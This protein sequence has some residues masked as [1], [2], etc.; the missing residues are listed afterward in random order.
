MRRIALVS[1]AVLGAAVTGGACGTAYDEAAVGAGDAGQGSD[2][3]EAI[4]AGPDASEPQPAPP[5]G[6][7]ICPFVS[8]P[9]DTPTCLDE[10]CQASSD[11]D[12]ER[13]SNTSVVDNQCE[14]TTSDATTSSFYSDWPR[15]AERVHLTLAFRLHAFTA[16]DR[17]IASVTGTGE[18]WQVIA[19][20]GMLEL[21]ELNAAGRRCAD[22]VAVSPGAEVHVFGIA[23]GSIPPNAAFAISVN[24]A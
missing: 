9:N 20:G 11:G 21:C 14:A 2:A 5:R 13:S 1:I 18:A 3:P 4:D 23:S 6:P 7:P 8:C 15:E 12:F 17:V 22:P 19:K 10:T 24:G 16:E